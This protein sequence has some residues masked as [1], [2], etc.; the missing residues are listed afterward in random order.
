MNRSIY[1]M[2]ILLFQENSLVQFDR[3]VDRLKVQI[4]CDG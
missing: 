2:N 3:T 4:G 1:L